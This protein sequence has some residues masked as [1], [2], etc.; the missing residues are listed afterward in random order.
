MGVSLK[1][2]KTKIDRVKTMQIWGSEGGRRGFTSTSMQG[3]RWLFPC[4]PPPASP[5][6]QSW[7]LGSDAF[8]FQF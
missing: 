5:F 4:S 7:P 1:T 3:L 2:E 6:A 8:V